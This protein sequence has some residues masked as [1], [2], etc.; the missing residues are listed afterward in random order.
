M[1]FLYILFLWGYNEYDAN[2]CIFF[3]EKEKKENNSE[4]CFFLI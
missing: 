2:F 4:V 1:S 3:T